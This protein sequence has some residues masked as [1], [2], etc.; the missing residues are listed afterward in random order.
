MTLAARS[1]YKTRDAKPGAQGWSAL[2][3]D[4]VRIAC[5]GRDPESFGP[6]VP[7]AQPAGEVR[8]RRTGIAKQQTLHIARNDERV[9]I[10]E[11]R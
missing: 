8:M 7:D 11:S 4:C 2:G 9:T 6:P 3:T 10:E 1:F 5:T